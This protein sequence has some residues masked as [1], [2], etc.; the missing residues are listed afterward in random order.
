MQ[1]LKPEANEVDKIIDQLID[2][3]SRIRQQIN[4]MDLKVRRKKTQGQA[5]FANQYELDVLA[6]NIVHDDFADFPGYIVSEERE[7]DKAQLEK[8]SMLLVVDPVDGSTNASHNIGYW[9][10]S[11]AL[12]WEGHVIAGVVV[13]QV[14]RRVFVATEDRG[15]TMTLS[16]GSKRILDP[17][18]FDQEDVGSPADNFSSS[19]ICFSSH[20]GPSIPFRHLRH[21]GSSALAICDTACGGFDAYIDDEDVL[22]KPWDLLAAEYIAEKAGCKVLR[23]DSEGLMAATGVFVTRSESLIGHFQKLFPH[24]FH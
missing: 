4:D 1:N 10:F 16:D 12:I 5:R 14:S 22:L 21:F 24:F 2:T 17:N 20:E 7:L 11:A 9:C 19:L 15:A 3:A 8:N 23:R 13:D 18:N 6:D